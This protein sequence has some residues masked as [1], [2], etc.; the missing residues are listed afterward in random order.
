M[1]CEI[2]LGL[3]NYLKDFKRMYYWCAPNSLKDQNV[4]PIVKQ[5][6]KKNIK[7]CS[8][9]QSTLGVGRH[10]GASGWD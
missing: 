10:V 5:W 3:H 4:G 6:E 1:F 2:S 7:A 9:T 8:L